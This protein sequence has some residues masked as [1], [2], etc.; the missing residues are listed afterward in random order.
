MSE[1]MTSESIVEAEW[2]LEG[3]WSKMRFAFQ[4]KKGAWS[5]VDV[6]AY[7]PEERHLIISE[8]KVRGPKNIVF[9]YTV[10]TEEEYGSILEYDDDNYFSF[11][12]HLPLLCSD[13][14]IFRDFRKMVKKIT[15]QLVSNYVVTEDAKASAYSSIKQKIEKFN[16]L[17]DVEFLLDTTLD[18]I[19]RII[20]K[21]RASGQGK[22][23]G[24]PVLDIAREINRYFYPSVR[25]AGRSKESVENV[26][27]EAISK[28]LKAIGSKNA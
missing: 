16:L 27:Q 2:L 12:R 20:V 18:V 25:Y 14:V 24:H 19:A 10:S 1:A 9:A 26:K 6:L 23:Y 11:L 5:D 21:E 4:T 3:F 7:N 22:R 13:G 15:V 8:S 28:F 17:V